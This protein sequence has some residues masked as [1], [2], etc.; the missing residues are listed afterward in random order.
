MYSS[1]GVLVISLICF[2]FASAHSGDACLEKLS[3]EDKKA[4]MALMETCKKKLNLEEFPKHEEVAKNGFDDKCFAKCKLME[5]KLINDQGAM[6]DAAVSDMVK[7]ALP[8][9]QADL[10]SLW[11]TCYESTKKAID[12]EG[13]LNEKNSCKAA[14]MLKHCFMEGVQKFC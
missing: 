11:K 7:K 14:A 8:D 6:D 13:G 12:A 10:L 5:M 2:Q 9:K 4:T 3:A 1:F